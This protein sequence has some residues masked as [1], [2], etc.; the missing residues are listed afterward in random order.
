MWD[1][2]SLAGGE[3]MRMLVVV[4]SKLSNY[5]LVSLGTYFANYTFAKSSIIN[6][7]KGKMLLRSVPGDWSSQLFL[8]GGL[9]LHCLLSHYQQRSSASDFQNNYKGC[10]SCLLR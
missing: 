9:T 2:P 3:V 1:W 5:C 6:V 4:F 10:S 7:E 8:G